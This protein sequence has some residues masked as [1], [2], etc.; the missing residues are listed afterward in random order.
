MT[1]IEIVGIILVLMLMFVVGCI[2]ASVSIGL[3]FI[4]TKIIKG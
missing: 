4:V 2:F 3:S 1:F